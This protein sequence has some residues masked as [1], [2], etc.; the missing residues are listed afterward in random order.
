MHVRVIAICLHNKPGTTRPPVIAHPLGEWT[1]ALTV[2]SLVGVW[3]AVPDT[4]PP[5]AAGC[6]LVGLGAERLVA[7]RAVGRPGT[8]ALVVAV[9]GAV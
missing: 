1:V 4:E 5:L 6:V 8:A 3:S 2:V 9:A 7:G